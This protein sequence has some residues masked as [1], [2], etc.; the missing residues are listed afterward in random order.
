MESLE[1]NLQYLMSKELIQGIFLVSLL[2]TINYYNLLALFMVLRPGEIISF[3]SLPSLS[4]SCTAINSKPSV[5]LRIFDARSGANLPLIAATNPG[6]SNPLQFCDSTEVCQAVL[7][8]N[9]NPGFAAKF[10]IRNITC[11]AINQTSP[12]ELFTSISHTLDF[13]DDPCLNNQCENG[14][15][16]QPLVTAK[17]GYVCRCTSGFGGPF[18]QFGDAC[19]MEPNYCGQNGIC[20]VGDTGTKFCTCLAGYSGLTCGFQNS[21]CATQSICNN[22]TCRPISSTI[23]GYF[24][25]CFAGFTGQNCESQFNPCL[26]N[27]VP[28]FSPESTTDYICKCT[29]DY[30][31][32]NCEIRNLCSSNPCRNGATCLSI[33][34]NNESFIC[35]CAPGFVGDFCDRNINDS[36]CVDNDPLCPRLSSI[37]QFGFFNGKTV[38]DL[39]PK[40]CQVCS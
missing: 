26:N 30:R 25:T 17:L 14:A 18:C 28:E 35:E 3:G 29:N 8:V 19:S 39:C 31:G 15:T 34:E 22:G 16:C 12:F 9:L 4:I 20:Q 32:K 21:L 6:S 27:G 13:N 23:E 24:C 7:I 40:T 36:T 1:I 38:K 5:N 2:Q 37:C 10:S 33:E 11:S